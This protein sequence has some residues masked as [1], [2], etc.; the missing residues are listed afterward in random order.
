MVSEQAVK[1]V[2]D[3]ADILCTNCILCIEI[4]YVNS[5]AFICSSYCSLCEVKGLLA[6]PAVLYIV[7]HKVNTYFKIPL[8]CT[9]HNAADSGYNRCQTYIYIA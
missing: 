2:D 6:R 9:A 5:I 4:M 3:V 7:M 1:K 8:F